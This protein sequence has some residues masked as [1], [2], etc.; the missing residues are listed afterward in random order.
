MNFSQHNCLH[1]CAFLSTGIPKPCGSRGTSCIIL[2]SAPHR[3][4][5]LEALALF[6]LR[7]SYNH[8]PVARTQLRVGAQLSMCINNWGTKNVYLIMDESG[9]DVIRLLAAD[10]SFSSLLLS[11]VPGLKLRTSTKFRVCSCVQRNSKLIT[12][13]S[14][15]FCFTIFIVELYVTDWTKNLLNKKKKEELYVLVWFFKRLYD[16]PSI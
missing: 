5:V 2:I 7:P 13:L 11:N 9:P 3:K 12:L 8:G 15:V 10:A 6:A 1:I 4:F 14:M 16:G